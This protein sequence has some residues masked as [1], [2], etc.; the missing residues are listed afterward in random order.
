MDDEV[1]RLLEAVAAMGE[2]K[3]DDRAPD[4]NCF[5]EWVPVWV[6]RKARELEAKKFK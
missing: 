6:I 3:F 2:G 4:Q 5:I 1:M